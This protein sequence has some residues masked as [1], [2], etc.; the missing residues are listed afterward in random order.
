M[1]KVDPIF[2]LPYIIT[3]LYYDIK[4]LFIFAIQVNFANKKI[5][6]K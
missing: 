2:I 3:K 5:Y 4:S 6:L 1:K